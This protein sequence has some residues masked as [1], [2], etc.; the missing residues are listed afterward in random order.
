MVLSAVSALGVLD[1]LDVLSVGSLVVWRGDV[2]PAYL[3]ELCLEFGQGSLVVV[4]LLVH[5][6][7]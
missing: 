2:V 5:C 7:C 6:I 3:V 4:L 1:V